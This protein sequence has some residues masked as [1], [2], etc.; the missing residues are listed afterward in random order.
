MHGWKSPFKGG[1]LK[2][3]EG[4]S[5]AWGTEEAIQRMKLVKTTEP[6]AT[7]AKFWQ[8][9]SWHSLLWL[10]NFL[11]RRIKEDRKSSNCQES[12]T[13]P[14]SK[15][16]AVW[17]TRNHRMIQQIRYCT[18]SGNKLPRTEQVKYYIS[19]QCYQSTVKWTMKLLHSS[20]KLGWNN[21]PQRLLL[22]LGTSNERF[23]W[24]IYC[25]IWFW[26]LTDYQRQWTMPLRNRDRDVVSHLN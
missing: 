24:K 7:K 3:L 16:K 10:S 22:M 17:E 20:T 14:I 18:I 13:V 5:A 11:N 23:K 15:R 26:V 1:Q 19:E 21:I 2:N 4:T 6:D 8:A 9:K 25:T 12:A